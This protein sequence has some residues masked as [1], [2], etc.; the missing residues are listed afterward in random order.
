MKLVIAEKPSVAQSIAKVLGATTKKDGYYEGNNYSVSWCVGHLV[1]LAPPESYNELYKKWDISSLPI[2]PQNWEYTIK[3]ATKT[4]F[5]V[6]KKLMADSNITSVVCATDAG[7]EGELIFR[8]TYN[9]ACCNKPVE[10]LWISSL[11]DSA[12]KSGFENLKSGS[13]YDNLYKSA[14]CRERADWLVGMNFTR[15]FTKVYNSNKPLNIGRVQTPTL[16]MIVE[17]DEQINSFK[18]EKYYK[19]ELDC[20]DF[21]AISDKIVKKI[22]ADDLATACNNKQAYVTSVVKEEKK[23]SAPKLYDLTTLQ[24]DANRLLGFT[25]QQTLEAVQ[26]LYDNKLST[27]PRTD[28]QYL[29]EDMEATA[30]EVIEIILEK[31]EFANGVNYTPN[32]NIVINNKKVSD[33]HAIIP[34]ANIAK[35]DLSALSDTDRKILCMIA[36]RLLVATAEKHIFENTNVILR[37]CD[38]DFFAKGKIV[39]QKGFKKLEDNFRNYLKCKD[40][41]KEAEDKTLP[42][43]VE[44]QTFMVLSAVIEH[45]TI[46]PKPYT[47]DTLLL[48]M[49]RAG[50]SEYDTDEVE[51]KGLGTPATRAS[52]IEKIILT[53]YAER[54]KNQIIS[55]EKGRN[56]IKIVP[57][58]IKSA[59]M[60]ADWENQ[61]VLISKG[62]ADS[63]E[64]INSINTYISTIISDTQA[65]TSIKESIS[66]L[67]EKEVIGKCPRCGAEIYEGKLNFYC[68]NKEC[69]F[70]LW[71]KNKFFE[72]KKKTITKAVAKK[73]LSDGKVHFK[74]LYSETTNKTYEA[75]IFLDDTSDKYVNFKLEFNKN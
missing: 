38:S 40:E 7:R 12:I 13:E 2:I 37:C 70:A 14:L 29:T 18:K 6:L 74:D 56:I 58:K 52:I 30:I 20:G 75:D 59:S 48:A 27:Y 1:A 67:P 69:Q 28:S 62:Q 31:F 36:N 35:A 11:E 22:N 23:V 46:P 33:H 15:L 73:L 8:H 34:T 71:K 55:T 63:D 39:V 25:A 43:V 19:V 5:N 42:P 64:F 60:T 68:S 57:E 24:R 26:R 72:S 66:S 44:Q 10:R 17:R 21:K 51:R 41:D 50:N 54:N 3:E 53:G 4:Q 9:K 47:E 16:A 49:E 45:F 32:I 65:D 61:L